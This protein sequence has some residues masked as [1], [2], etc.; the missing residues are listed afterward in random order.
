[1][2]NIHSFIRIYLNQTL[3]PLYRNRIQKHRKTEGETEKKNSYT[4]PCLNYNI[5]GRRYHNT[6]SK[7]EV[8]AHLVNPVCNKAK[9]LSSPVAKRFYGKFWRIMD[10]STWNHAWMMCLLDPPDGIRPPTTVNN[11]VAVHCGKQSKQ[12]CKQGWR[13]S[14]YTLQMCNIEIL[15][16]KRVNIEI[17][18]KTPIAYFG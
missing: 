6:K 7:F 2:W 13:P 14:L 3:G 12:S 10:Q 11:I 17:V 16:L 15:N 8:M 5:C 18:N 1:M 9:Y 4:L